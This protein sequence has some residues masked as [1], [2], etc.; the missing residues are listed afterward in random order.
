MSDH[1]L[2]E[3]YD[4]LNEEHRHYR[5]AGFWT[6]V[7][8]AFVDFLVFIPLLGLLV[9]GLIA[10]KSL[11]IVLSVTI[12]MAAYKPL[13]EYQYGAT[14]GKMAVGIKVIDE[15]GGLLS[16]NQTIIRYLPWLIGN[17]ISIFMYIELFG[18]GA[19]Q[20]VNG[21]MEYVVF[22][23]EYSSSSSNLSSLAGW[24]VLISALGMLFNDQKQAL[25]DKMAK[26]YCIHKD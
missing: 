18:I 12:I 24:L 15:E 1:I 17:V 8:A 6:R 26:T 19:F 11:P 5:Y 9:Y 3:N 21:F 2:D 20:D 14:L 13:M 7:G 22:T 16:S 25:H 4:Q 10:L 23:Q